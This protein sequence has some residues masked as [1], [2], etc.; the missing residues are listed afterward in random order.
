MNTYTAQVNAL[1]LMEI[2]GINT[3]GFTFAWMGGGSTLGQCETYPRRRIRLNR[4]YV[5]LNRWE[6]VQDTILHEIAHALT[7]IRNGFQH[8]YK[9]KGRKIIRVIHGAKFYAVCREIGAKDQRC[10]DKGTKMP[11]KK[12]A[13]ARWILVNTIDGSTVRTYKRRPSQ[14]VSCLR[15]IGRPETLGKLVLRAL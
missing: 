5:E 14:D 6:E 11:P 9:R 1:R 4:G 8:E 3:H 15:L 7:W 10:A 12:R 13:V 2:H